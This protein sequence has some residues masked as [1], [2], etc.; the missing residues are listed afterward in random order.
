MRRPG[1]SAFWDCSARATS[2]TDRRCARSSSG[3]SQRL[4]WRLRPP[5]T[6]TWPTPSELLRQRAL[7]PL[8]R[9]LRGGVGCRLELEGHDDLRNAFGRGRAE[10]IDRA[11]GV[12]RLL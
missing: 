2:L 11:D 12:D 4:T 10:R 3:F 7:V 5:M 6:T 1:M 8:A 9:P